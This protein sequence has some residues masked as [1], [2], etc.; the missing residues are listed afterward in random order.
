MTNLTSVKTIEIMV[1]EGGMPMLKLKGEGGRSLGYLTPF[2]GYCFQVSFTAE[3]NG[4]KG[5]TSVVGLGKLAYA[6]KHMSE[7]CS[8]SSL[9]SSNGDSLNLVFG[10]LAELAIYKSGSILDL[11]EYADYT[12]FNTFVSDCVKYI[13]E[14]I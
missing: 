1:A 8:L 2:R 10:D 14:K 4:D 7:V 5:S 6:L 9:Y 3:G 13:R 12:I 11:E